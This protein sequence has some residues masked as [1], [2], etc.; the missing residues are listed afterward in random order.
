MLRQLRQ[1]SGHTLKDA[2]AWLNMGESAV[3]KIEKAK[4]AIKVQTVRALGQ[5]YDVDA[6]KLDYLLRLASESNERG[7]WTAYRDTVPEWFRQFVGLEADAL[8][9]WNYE[10]EHV[11]GLLQ[12]PEYVRA[13]MR[14]NRPDMSDAEV[15]RQVKIRRER[16]AR[17]NGDDP[18]RLHFYLNEAVIRR[19]VGGPEVM[20]DQLHRLIDASRSPHT[21]LRILPFA[22]GPHPAMSGAFVMMQFPEEDAPAFVYVDNERGA[23]YQEDPGDIDRY[24]VVV[25]VLE[26]LSLSPD[27]SRGMLAEAI[28]EQ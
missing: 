2:A 28:N 11:P 1:D 21:T 7:W 12:T 18:P 9:L 3:S 13:L 16:Q 4:T 26:R 22:T 10:A 20:R 5:L 23:I 14:S 15:D 25:D 24:A 17:L 8:D 19:P 6:A 27:D